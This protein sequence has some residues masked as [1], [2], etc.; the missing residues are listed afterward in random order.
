MPHHFRTIEQF[1]QLLEEKISASVVDPIGRAKV[2]AYVEVLDI[3]RTSNIG[4]IYPPPEQEHEWPW[5]KDCYYVFNGCAHP[6]QC[7][8]VGQCAVGQCDVN[9]RIAE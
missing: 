3:L 6:D 7:R 1:V 9:K 5:E 8:A 2:S 4:I